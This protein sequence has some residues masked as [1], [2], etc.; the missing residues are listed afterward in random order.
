VF[1]AAVDVYEEYERAYQ[2]TYPSQTIRKFALRRARRKILR[3][4]PEYNNRQNHYRRSY[5]GERRK[6]DPGFR[7][8]ENVR[9]AVVYAMG[10]GNKAGARTFEILGYTKHDLMSHLEKLFSP[11]MSWDN[12]GKGGWEI[13]HIIPLAA[14]DLTDPQ[15]LR[16]CW[17]LA[18]LQ[19]LWGPDN[20]KKGSKLG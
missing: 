11:G 6:T 18:N 3:Q 2:A 16:E 13:D 8:K 9:R 20:W 14:F 15:E 19:P 10:A 12:Y 1:E 4:D 17:N 5:D 7:I